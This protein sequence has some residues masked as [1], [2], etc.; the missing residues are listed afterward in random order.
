MAPG[1][2]LPAAG[3]GEVSLGDYLGRSCVVLVFLRGFF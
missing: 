2:V 1:F 3:G